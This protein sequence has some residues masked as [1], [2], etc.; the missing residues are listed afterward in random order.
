MRKSKAGA[1]W[2]GAVVV[3][4][5]VAGIAPPAQAQSGDTQYFPLL[6][7]RTGPYAA[8][9]AQLANGMIDYLKLV[10]ANGGVNGVMLS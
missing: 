8:N 7:Y 5:G 4:L 6:V 2:L 1:A 9:G 3:G 10:N